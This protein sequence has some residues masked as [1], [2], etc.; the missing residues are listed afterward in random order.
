MEFEW[1][2]SK[3]QANIDK[4]GYDFIRAIDVLSGDHVVVSSQYG[5]DEPR[6][7]AIGYIEGRLAT[8][9]YTMRGETYRVISLRQAAYA[10]RRIY[11]ALH[12]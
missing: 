3:R 8:L 9:V 10:E 7:L 11:E 6:W 2:E 5:G 1:D 4:H 12:Q